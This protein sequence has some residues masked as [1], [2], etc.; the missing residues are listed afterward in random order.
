[1]HVQVPMRASMQ[2]FRQPIK[3]ETPIPGLEL[4]IVLGKGSYGIVF[5][6]R[7]KE[8]NVAVKVTRDS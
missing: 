5:R 8:R 1:M 2:G 3:P 6:G 4:G 7:Y